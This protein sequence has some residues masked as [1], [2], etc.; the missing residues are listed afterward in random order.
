MQQRDK[1]RSFVL[2]ERLQYVLLPG[3]RLQDEA[4]EDPLTA[5]LEERMADSEL[6]WKNKLQRPLQEVFATCLSPSAL[7]VYCRV[8]KDSVRQRALAAQDCQ[9]L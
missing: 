3:E 9:S 1:G 8:L 5:A 7:Q 4:A 2:G 6:Y